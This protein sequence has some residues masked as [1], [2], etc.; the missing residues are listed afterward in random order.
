[1][2]R[3]QQLEDA[4]KEARQV[5]A[6]IE[7]E[8][9]RMKTLKERLQQVNLSQYVK[10]TAQEASQA[11]NQQQSDDSEGSPKP[12]PPKEEK[13]KSPPTKKKKAV[14]EENKFDDNYAFYMYYLNSTG[15]LVTPLEQMFQ[16]NADKEDKLRRFKE[17]QEKQSRVV[18]PPPPEPEPPKKAKR[19]LAKPKV[20]PTKDLRAQTS[21]SNK[22]A[23]SVNDAKKEAT[24]KKEVPSKVKTLATPLITT[25]TKA[26]KAAPTV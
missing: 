4:V 15:Q 3:Q 8:R 22:R 23:S 5:N 21:Q 11:G 24:P 18:K 26:A 14:P 1:M 25:T 13:K 6:L 12:P 20:D 17:K 7:E 16:G 9:L 10:M 2:A 19:V